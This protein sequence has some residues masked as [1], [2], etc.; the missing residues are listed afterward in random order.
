MSGASFDFP[1]LQHNLLHLLVGRLELPDQ[2]QHHLPGVVVGVF[3]IHQW[4]QVTNCFEESSQTLKKAQW[5]WKKFNKI[6]C[7]Y[8]YG[9]KCVM[10]NSISV[11]L[12]SHSKSFKTDNSCP[13]FNTQGS[14]VPIE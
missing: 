10:T 9:F 13:L 4:N 6:Y 7:K 3:S 14:F 5:K 8:N 12:I 1:H 2:D 11:G